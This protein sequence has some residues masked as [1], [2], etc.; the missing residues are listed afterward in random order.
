MKLEI[1]SISTWE[2][3]N[4]YSYNPINR[5]VFA[6]TVYVDI[7]VKNK[8]GTDRFSI[9][10]ATPK[11]LENLNTKEGIIATRPLVIMQKYNYHDLQTWLI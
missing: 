9:K 3:P 11:G 4:M 2:H 10:V 8:S 5:D 6:E 1:K 7:G